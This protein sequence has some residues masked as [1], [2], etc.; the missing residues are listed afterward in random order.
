MKIKLTFAVLLFFGINSFAQTFADSLMVVLKKNNLSEVKAFLDKSKHKDTHALLNRQILDGY[1]ELTYESREVPGYLICIISNGNKVIYSKVISA[2]KKIAENEDSAAVKQ[3]YKTYF[4]F[5]EAKVKISGFFAD[6]IRYGKGCGFVGVD[7]P[8]R[9]KMQAL[10]EAKNEKELTKWLQSP[11]TEKQLY[12]VEGLR[13]LFK[14][15]MGV[16][17]LQKRLINFITFKKGNYQDCNGC[18]Y[19]SSAIY[20]LFK[21]D[22]TN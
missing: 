22:H 17:P 1:Y 12:A 5:F 10:V 19:S 20:D 11:V 4:K 15:G 8:E 16:S 3:F 9:K 18:I 13:G 7:P 2:R 6:T 21:K 14:S